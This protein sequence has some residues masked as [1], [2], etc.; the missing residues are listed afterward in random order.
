M[1]IYISTFLP[2]YL[3]IDLPLSV[4]R[5]ISDDASTKKTYFLLDRKAFYCTLCLENNF[6]CCP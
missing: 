5:I 3:S 6:L 4:P 2:M 1:F